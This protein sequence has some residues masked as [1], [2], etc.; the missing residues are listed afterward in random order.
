[1]REKRFNK[2]KENMI[3]LGG[4][5]KKYTFLYALMLFLIVLFELSFVIYWLLNVKT[6]S[7]SNI[8]YLT[9]YLFLIFASIIGIIF[10]SL[11]KKDKISLFTMSIILHLYSFSIMAWA[12][13]ITLLD[14]NHNSDVIVF[15]T[16]S[17]VL[18]GILVISPI[19][20]TCT[21]LLSIL[22][23]IIF[24]SIYHY[25]YF[26]GIAAYMNFMV[27]VIMVIIMAFRHYSI[28]TKEAK[29]NDYLWE[30]S[31]IDHLTGLGNETSYF[32]EAER[33]IEKISKEDVEYGIVVLD[34]NNV[35]TTNDTYGHR[36]GCHLIVETGKILPSIF[37][38][39]K[40]FHVGGDEFIVILE[41]D[42]YNNIENII[43][44]FDEKLRYTKTTF[45]NIELELSVARGYFI[46]KPNMSYKEVFQKA[47]DLM[48]VNKKEVKKEYNMI[49]R[50]S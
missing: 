23:I 25:S 10:L 12:T 20:Y 16:V 7:F 6:Y 44:K 45:E 9:S 18:S 31:F 37:K 38:T 27:F 41:G 1:M 14:L 30:L 13:T 2:F 22:T 32:E 34:V 4:F 26:N 8:V 46:S 42:D 3:M 5:V 43:K 47:D 33:L 36:F 49:I 21:T 48:Y 35:K 28:R 29:L 19:F 50:E 11:F 39:S 40:L 24:N 15:L 17:M